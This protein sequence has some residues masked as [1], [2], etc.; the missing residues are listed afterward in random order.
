MVKRSRRSRRRY[1]G[2]E[3]A[4]TPAGVACANYEAERNKK[5]VP[6]VVKEKLKQICEDAK[7]RAAKGG[8]T[9]RRRKTSRR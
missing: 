7:A 8:R 4:M 6:A 1:G 5:H 3:A 2:D 9:R